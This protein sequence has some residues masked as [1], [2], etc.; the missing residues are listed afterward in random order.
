MDAVYQAAKEMVASNPLSVSTEREKLLARMER[1]NQQPIEVGEVEEIFIEA[2]EGEYIK[3]FEV[4]EHYV[5]V[6]LS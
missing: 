6:L 2:A 4:F 1:E 5:A 3:H